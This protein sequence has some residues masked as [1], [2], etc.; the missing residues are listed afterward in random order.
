MGHVMKFE[1]ST[2]LKTSFV[3]LILT[4]STIAQQDECDFPLGIENGHIPDENF[5]ASASHAE[6]S[7]AKFARLNNEDGAGAWC[8]PTVE[9]GDQSQYLEIEL[10]GI[11]KITHMIIQ[12]R[13]MHTE[14]V[15][16]VMVNSSLDG[17]NWNEFGL[18]DLHPSN[19]VL[20]AELSPAI[21]GKFVRLI[22]VTDRAMPVCIRTE[23]FGC[24]RTD[25]FVGYSLSIAPRSS[26]PE[27]GLDA[28]RHGIGRLSDSLKAEFLT[29][30]ESVDIRLSWSK[31]VNISEL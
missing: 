20:H 25:S 26:T 14:T 11:A 3:L 2:G 4:K 22:P 16:K 31:A 27:F 12:G 9:A 17:V 24:Y 23:F 1:K 18:L 29:F 13:H 10:S 6:M 28:R 7:S 8:H 21:N 30:P 15:Q 5:R 19:D